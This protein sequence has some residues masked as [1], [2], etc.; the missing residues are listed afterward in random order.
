[1]CCRKKSERMKNSAHYFL[2]NLSDELDYFQVLWV[3]KKKTPVIF[4]ISSKA[5]F[6]FYQL[7]SNSYNNYV[8]GCVPVG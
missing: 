5:K 3:Q 2:F 7:Y 4:E 1:M 8:Y 6:C